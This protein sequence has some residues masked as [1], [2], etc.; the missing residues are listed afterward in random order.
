MTGRQTTEEGL[1]SRVE[2]FCSRF[3]MRSVVAPGNAT[4]PASPAWRRLQ[5]IMTK[6]MSR[7]W[8]HC[9]GIAGRWGKWDGLRGVHE[10]L[11][12]GGFPRG[13]LHRAGRRPDYFQAA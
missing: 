12:L 3:A 2:I 11:V 8:I 1:D 5:K 13:R 9:F 4:N 7:N 10:Y 6:I